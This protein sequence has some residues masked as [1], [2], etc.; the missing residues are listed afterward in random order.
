MPKIHVA[1]VAVQL[2][3][4]RPGRASHG[5]PTKTISLRLPPEADLALGAAAVATG[6]T[7]AAVAATLLTRA[8]A[9]TQ[10]SA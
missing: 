9:Q 6:S 8:L 2:R 1:G 5:A 7:R 10:E 3:A 4:P